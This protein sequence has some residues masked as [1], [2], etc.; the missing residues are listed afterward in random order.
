MK[1]F[2]MLCVAIFL[3]AD[4]SNILLKIDKIEK[5]SPKFKKM[6]IRKCYKK[7][8]TIHKNTIKSI[9]VIRNN[10][11]ITLQA[12][13]NKKALIN[14]KWLKEGD[15]IDGY[16][17]VKIYKKKIILKRDSKL[18]ILK[19]NTNILKVKK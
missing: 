16:K 6:N 1:Q 10:F 17:V 11:K 8:E 5:Y 15:F 19:F 9:S 7:M 18:G 12:V 3:Y 2:L 14:N 4:V 13:F